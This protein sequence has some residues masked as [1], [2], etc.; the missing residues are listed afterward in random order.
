[1]SEKPR[2][3]TVYGALLLSGAA[4]LTYQTTWARMLHRVFGVSDLAIATV[5]ATFFLGLG[6]GSWVGARRGDRSPEPA[7]IY[8]LLEAGIAAWALGSLWLVPRIHD[9]YAGTAGGL[10]FAPLTAVR[11]GLALLILLPPTVMMGATLPLLVTAVARRGLGWEGSAT[12]LYATNTFG[13]VAGAGLTG[14]LLLPQW[15]MRASIGIAAAASLAAGALVWVGWRGAGDDGP[16][17]G[18]APAETPPRRATESVSSLGTAALL[19]AGAGFASLAGEVLWTRVLRLVVQGTTAAFATMLVNFLAGIGLGSLLANRLAKRW[20]ARWLFGLTQLALVLLTFCT[21][22]VASQVPRLMVLVR[23]APEVVPTHWLLLL[24]VG[25][26]LLFPLALV[27]G[28]SVPLAWRMAGGAPGAA[29]DH[30]GKVLAAN[31]SGGL[32]GSLAAG[33]VFVPMLGAEPSIRLV[34]LVHAALATL[35]F[36]QASRGRPWAHRLPWLLGP[37]AVVAMAMAI[38]PSL[39]LPYLLGARQDVVRAVIEGPSDAWLENLR[40]LEEGRNTTVTVVEEEDGLALYN[41]GRPESGFDRGEPGFG[42]E[43]VALGS[44]P[45]LYRA[46]RPPG[47]ARALVVGL[48]AGHSAAVALAGPYEQVSVV[49]LEGAVVRAARFL[50]RTRDEPFPLDDPRASLVVDDAR[51]Q[52]TLATPGSLGAVISQPSHPWLAGSSALYTTEF[53]EEVHRALAADGVFALWA[54]LFRIR[55]RHLRQIVATL[56][57][58][59]GAV[60]GY[61]VEN[62]SFVFVAAKEPLVLDGGLH[63]MASAGGPS[64]FLEKVDLGGLPALASR[65]ELDDAGARSFAEGAPPLVDDRPAL[66]F[67]LARLPTTTA[68]SYADL[69]EVLGPLPWMDRETFAAI[70]AGLRL[71]VL[72]RRIR[73]CAN[74]PP[75]LARLARGLGDYPLTPDQRATVGGAL[76][77][78]RGDVR[79]ALARYSSSAGPQATE[80]R[81]VLLDAERAFGRIVD[82]MQAGTEGIPKPM[83]LRA[84]LAT[85]SAEAARLA[86]ALSGP[87]PAGLTRVVAALAEGCDAV[88]A[89]AEEEP[90]AF[91]D[92]HAATVGIECAARAERPERMLSLDAMRQRARR[93]LAARLAAEGSAAAP[94]NPKRAMDA[95]RRALMANP[96]QAPAA[97]GLAELLVQQEK[98]TEARGVLEAALEASAG[99]PWATERLAETAER[100]AIDGGSTEAPQPEAGPLHGIATPPFTED[101]SAGE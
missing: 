66:E 32:L 80:A 62:S 23:G 4:A 21:M 76:A 44:M 81:V 31:T 74:R 40:F 34:A 68:L 55:P 99:L 3:A 35:A 71:E 2:I 53:F 84:A 57:E 28:T 5:L 8:A 75:Q 88:V 90:E 61:V 48:G 97:T 70:P 13:A 69:D 89:L 51:A 22:A 39:H 92:E 17:R 77:E 33:F 72:L 83:A 56:L 47:G 27:L 16:V 18:G 45:A 85:R 54:N 37:L 25:A 100:L 101:R 58:V 64:R 29:A 63:R 14:L 46:S 50:Y 24:G 86:L 59:F 11:F 1:M 41:D 10:G 15:G 19:A 42:P 65:L 67:E 98:T 6:I 12:R 96:A 91:A 36:A 60:H 87:A 52:L 95:F 7:R 93:A 30:S 43:L 82:L 20:D 73:W 79:A 26:V 78:A 49:E 94:W 38:G 9:L